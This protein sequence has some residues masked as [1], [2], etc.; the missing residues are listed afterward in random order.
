MAPLNKRAKMPKVYPDY[1][2]PLSMSQ[3]VNRAELIN[4]KVKE[5][6]RLVYSCFLWENGSF[7]AGTA[8][9]ENIRTLAMDS[10]VTIPA[11]CSV[12]RS[13]R[14][15]HGLRHVALYLACIAQ[16]KLSTAFRKHKNDRSYVQ[17]HELHA[18]VVRDTVSRVCL[19]PDDMSEMIAL[20]WALPPGKKGVVP[21]AMRKGL[22]DA[23]VR[24]A[25]DEDKLARFNKPQAIKLK[26][27][28]RLVHP[29]P[30]TAMQKVHL[31]KLD[32]DMLTAPVTWESELSAKG[33]T[34]ETWDS[35]LRGGHLSDIAFLR[36]LRNMLVAGIEYRRVMYEINKREF[37]GVTPF[38]FIAAKRALQQAGKGHVEVYAELGAAMRKVGDRLAQLKGRTIVLVDVS[39]S[40]ES[41]LSDK[42]DLTRMDAAVAL[43]AIAPCEGK[44]IV[45]FGSATKPITNV[46]TADPLAVAQHIID[47]TI[48][49]RGRTNLTEAVNN[50]RTVPHERLIVITDE[51]SHSRT[52]PIATIANRSYMINVASNANTVAERQN[53]WHNMA[54]FSEHV[55]KWI[56]GIEKGEA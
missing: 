18:Q 49:L 43:A 4:D 37:N 29:K 17:T 28:M 32:K 41:R 44:V 5:L 26:D 31:T 13:A 12:A 54:G 2:A 48:S 35:L 40:M 42:S 30:K 21:N 20:A 56:D 51:A 7:G 27:V 38:R 8:L 1:S 24:F 34:E 47:A 55:F 6:E 15:D 9:A 11:L 46:G 52:P 36:N 10:L 22:A 50:V 23:F 53:G 25:S 33:N 3:A 45:A 19:R 14:I 16:L 39:G